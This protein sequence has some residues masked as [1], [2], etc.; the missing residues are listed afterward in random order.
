MAPAPSPSTVE[1]RDEHVGLEAW[2]NL[3][4]AH[5]HLI[6]ELDD[7]L[8]ERHSLALG[9][10]D[11]LV[12]LANA[13]G[14][15]RSMCALAGA[16]LLTP[17]GLS[18]RIDRLEAAGFVARKRAANDARMIEACLTSSGKRLLR[19]LRETHL[20][21]VKERFVDRF[22]A[23]ELDTLRELLGRVTGEEP[24]AQQSC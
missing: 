16:V 6:R 11:V 9:D 8:R 22:N 2:R 23:E 18:R 3:L 7:E 10:Y 14:Q 20:A 21:G 13:P 24:G 17:S 4:R 12:N 19:G 5:A 1:A 15:R